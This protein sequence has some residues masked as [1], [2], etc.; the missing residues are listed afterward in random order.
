MLIF[1][2]NFSRFI[3]NNTTGRSARK[4]LH[5]NVT[6]YKYMP[7]NNVSNQQNE[8]NK[9]AKV[10]GGLLNTFYESFIY[11][12]GF[13]LS[14]RLLDQIFGPRTYDTFNNNT[15]NY[16]NEN[17]NTYANDSTNNCSNEHFNNNDPTI[18]DNDFQ[19]DIG[20]DDDTF[21]F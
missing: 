17:T 14:N 19:Q 16:A 9:V 15:D 18:D 1:K 5:K 21:E 4:N 2:R 13:F 10:G 12:C 20:L 6:Q 11:G 8:N 3:N 7:N